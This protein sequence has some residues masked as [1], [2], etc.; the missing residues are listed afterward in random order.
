[1]RRL[2]ANAKAFVPALWTHAAKEARFEIVSQA[3][4]ERQVQQRCTASSRPL[5]PTTRHSL[6]YHAGTAERDAACQARIRT[7]LNLLALARYPDN[8]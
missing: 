4:T 3:D 8:P 2:H 6:P 7:R 1:M 5:Q